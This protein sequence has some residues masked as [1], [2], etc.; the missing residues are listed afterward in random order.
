MHASFSIDH[1]SLH[2]VVLPGKKTVQESAYACCV[3]YMGR[4]SLVA[5]LGVHNKFLFMA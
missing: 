2:T 3:R 1:T 5:C 4:T